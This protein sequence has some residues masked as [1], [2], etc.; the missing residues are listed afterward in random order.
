[1]F[2]FLV[3]LVYTRSRM[4]VN[5]KARGVARAL[6]SREDRLA[7]LRDRRTREH[8][9]LLRAAR[10]VFLRRGY[11]QTRVED[12]L[13]EA[14]I[15]T[16]ALYRF[17]AGKD[18]LFLELFDRANRAA[19]R[20][21]RDTVARHADP[22]AQLDAYVDASLDLAYDPRLRRETALFANV[23]GELA[24]RHAREVQ[25]CRE[26]LVGVLREIVER[27]RDAGVFPAAEPEIDAWALHGAI[28]SL[29]S[30]VLNGDAPPA[31]TRL[32]RRLRALCR[33]ALAAR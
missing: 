33:A 29:M 26:Q 21:L 30:H 7:R 4:A 9:A 27:G 12:V 14:G 23:P 31:R 1:M 10:R 24:E 28:G 6:A 19:M 8:E 20:R 32:A 22:A 2:S 18:D 11:A 25:A 16:R 13:R 17:H 3:R 5:G 15:S